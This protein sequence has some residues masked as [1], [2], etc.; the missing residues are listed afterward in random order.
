MVMEAA[1]I[2]SFI[3]MQPQ[4]GFQFLIIALDAPAAHRSVHQA[5]Q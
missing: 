4:L 3:V 1:P 2:P 5:L